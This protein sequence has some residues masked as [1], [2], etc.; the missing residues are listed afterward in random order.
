MSKECVSTLAYP[1]NCSCDPNCAKKEF[2]FPICS[3]LPACFS[4]ASANLWPG[5][6]FARIGCS[7]DETCGAAR[8]GREAMKCAKSYL[9]ICFAECQHNADVEGVAFISSA[10]IEWKLS[11]EEPRIVKRHM[12][13][14]R[15]TKYEVRTSYFVPRT[16]VLIINNTRRKLLLGVRR[17]FEH[18]FLQY[19][20][21]LQNALIL[22][23]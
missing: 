19:D 22:H 18:F 1:V 16:S 6:G 10:C 9:I 4:R 11:L 23:L 3:I 14:V 15:G 2:R 7:P 13:K 5:R 12:E 17:S 8:P 21:V 20:D